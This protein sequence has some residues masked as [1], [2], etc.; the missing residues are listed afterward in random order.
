MGGDGI[1]GNDAGE[2]AV[3]YRLIGDFGLTILAR[4]LPGI[5]NFVSIPFLVGLLGPERYAAIGLFQTMQML[6]GLLD[7]G[8]SAAATRQSAWLTG[9]NASP[10]R[11]QRLLVTLEA[12][13]LSACAV[14]ALAGLFA[15][16]DVLWLVFGA[17]L[18]RAGVDRLVGALILLAVATRFPVSFYCGFLAGRGWLS[19]ANLATLV[20]DTVRILGAV[21]VLV[22]TRGS[23]AA[24][25]AWNV[26]TALAMTLAVS[27]ACR[28]S[29]PQPHGA[30]RP[31]LGTFREI[32]GLALSSGV[33]S[34]MFLVANTLDKVALPRFATARDFGLYVAVGQ[35]A[36]IAF[37]VI[38]AIWTT[39]H[40]RILSSLARGD[41]E[42]ARRRVQG[43]LCLA[44]AVLGG[45]MIG[46]AVAGSALLP[47][48]VRGAHTPGLETVLIAL[49]AG[50]STA[51]LVMPALSLQQ[52]GNNVWPSVAALAISLATVLICWA[53]FIRRVDPTVVAVA[54]ASVYGLAFLLSGPS[55]R[56]LGPGGVVDWA[57]TVAGF[58]T[59]CGL[60]LLVM[61]PAV[62]NLP[63][64]ARI[65]AGMLA[66]ST[67]AVAVA[68]VSADM[69]LL[70]RQIAG[71]AI[72]RTVAGGDPG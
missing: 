4:V 27:F 67:W 47:L 61:A 1:G 59:A 16:R 9:L 10:E 66:A 14:I 69:R 39:M 23:L 68:L 19:T 43:L 12:V 7:M 41:T 21:G 71:A 31:S 51:G 2:T 20:V 32:E 11:L 24:F 3:P 55:Y 60:G 8:L 58:A 45:A 65:A 63:P 34:L 44:V 40:P 37:V 46:A 18:E 70:A 64:E 29:I 35:L 15:G 56:R 36:V 48:W 28:R 6:I 38:Q 49:V 33:L 62:A 26:A 13:F 30:V 50:Y 72:R 54:W 57:L 5:L 42:E 25:F 53:A 22:A 52:A 17:D